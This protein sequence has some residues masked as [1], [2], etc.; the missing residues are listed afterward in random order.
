MLISIPTYA[1]VEIL[2]ETNDREKVIS[3]YLLV[4]TGSPTPFT[5]CVVCPAQHRVSSRTQR[6]RHSVPVHSAQ[7]IRSRH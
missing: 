1:Y 4:S 7:A 2:Q 3:F 6:S 5:F